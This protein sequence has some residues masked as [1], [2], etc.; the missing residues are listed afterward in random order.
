MVDV[1]K[2]FFINLEIRIKLWYLFNRLLNLLYLRHVER[3][4][5]SYGIINKEEILAGNKV[6]GKMLYYELKKCHKVFK[7][8]FEGKRRHM[9][10]I[11]YDLGFV[12][13]PV[14]VTSKKADFTAVLNLDEPVFYKK[15]RGKINKIIKKI[16]MFDFALPS[17]GRKRLHVR[18][19]EDMEKKCWYLTVHVDETN[20]LYPRRGKISE[21]FKTHV[22]HVQES[23]YPAGEILF[24]EVLDKN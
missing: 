9:K 13:D 16:P 18:A 14:S 24:E 8:E 23:N 6:L 1:I 15:I 22:V 10:K 12:I 2:S 5:F 19:F 4:G 21:F 17:L 7:F 3:V 11:L 20:P